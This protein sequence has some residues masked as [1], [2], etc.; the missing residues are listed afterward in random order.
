VVSVGYGSG[1]QAIANLGIV[2]PTRMDYPGS[3][4]SVRA[5]ALYVGQILKE[6]TGV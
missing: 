5:V 3:M 6:Q 2:G 4:A 1:D